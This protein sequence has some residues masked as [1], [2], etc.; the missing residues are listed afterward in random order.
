MQ[1]T[2]YFTCFITQS[3]LLVSKDIRLNPTNCLIR[4]TSSNRELRN[5]TISNSV[6]LYYK[7]FVK[8]YIE[9]TTKL[10]FFWT[11]DTALPTSDPLRFRKIYLFFIKMIVTDQIK[12]LDRKIE[13]NKP[14]YDLDGK[15][16]KIS[17]NLDKY[18]YL[19]DDDLNYKPGTVEQLKF[20]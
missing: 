10:Y 3:Y 7:D 15:A 11:I 17:G 8:I 18:K 1:K 12:I 6:H 4:K 14:P 2:K 9:C 19:T 5:I 20:D 16:A 13:Q